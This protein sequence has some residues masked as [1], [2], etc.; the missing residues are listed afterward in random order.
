VPGGGAGGM[1]GGWYG[2]RS[3]ENSFCEGERTGRL[4][5]CFGSERRE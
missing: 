1:R 2:G 5:H 4:T 3:G